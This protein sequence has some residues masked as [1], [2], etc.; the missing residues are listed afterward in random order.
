L[1]DSHCDM[2]S[3]G[4]DKG[5]T[6]SS[7]SRRPAFSP[8]DSLA[9]K[10]GLSAHEYLEES[11]DTV[12]SILDREKFNAVPEMAKSDFTIKKHLGKGSFSD[13]F[14][15]VGKGQSGKSFDTNATTITCETQPN[16]RRATRGRRASLSSLINKSTLGRPAQRTDSRPVFAMK[17]LRPQI[18]S[19]E[20]LFHTGAE[21]LVHESA[22]LASLNHRH[23]IKLYGRAPGN[24][25]EVF[26][27]NDGYGYFIIIDKLNETLNDRI[28]TWKQTKGISQGPTARQ[29]EVARSISDAMAYLHLHKIV[30]CDLKPD[31]VGFDCSGVLKLFDFGFAT[32]LPEKGED[33]PAGLIF[34]RCG[35]PRYMA[36]E[37]GLSL[38]YRQSADV[39]SFG[40]LLWEICALQK[41]FSYIT[42]SSEF[43]RN[44]FAE[45]ARP[46]MDSCWPANIKELMS[47]CWSVTPSERP[48]MVD[49]K[50]LLS[51]AIFNNATEVEAPAKSVFS[52]MARRSSDCG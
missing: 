11:F 42:S 2:N 35:T 51:L 31:N 25:T 10:V 18:R 21:D 19:D 49:I 7:E 22:I 30:F 40:I 26:M 36:P 15:V 45:G 28:V 24:L 44:V 48:N 34:D 3:Q 14:H 38:G 8:E 33:N 5:D 27:L 52:M 17:C 9:L 4:M 12:G 43:E 1:D 46:L 37:V 47:S 13:V 32:G 50:S 39:Y 6:A 29:L 16:R 41:P 20:D 23:I